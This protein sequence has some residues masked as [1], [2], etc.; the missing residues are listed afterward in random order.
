ME[1]LPRWELGVHFF[2]ESGTEDLAWGAARPSARVCQDSGLRV[3]PELVSQD[4]W[5]QGTSGCHPPRLRLPLN[6]CG[7]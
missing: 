3:L 5:T 1:E 6:S 7:S 2:Y 4:G